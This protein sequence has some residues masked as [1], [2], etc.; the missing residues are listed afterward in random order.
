MPKRGV[1]L[2]ASS[3]ISVFVLSFSGNT[4]ISRKIWRGAEVNNDQKGPQKVPR[5]S[6]SLASISL[7]IIEQP[8]SYCQ[9]MT[10]MLSNRTAVGVV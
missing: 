8:I 6:Q 4:Q 10:N 2:V 7:S 1:G 5:K 9:Q 3:K